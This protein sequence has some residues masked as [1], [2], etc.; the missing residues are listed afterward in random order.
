MAAPAGPEARERAEVAGLAT[1][2]GLAHFTLSGGRGRRLLPLLPDLPNTDCRVGLLDAVATIIKRDGAYACVPTGHEEERAEAAPAGVVALAVLNCRGDVVTVTI[3]GAKDGTEEE[4]EAAPNSVTAAA[5]TLEAAATVPAKSC[6]REG[7][8]ARRG[9]AAPAAPGDPGLSVAAS[10][11]KPSPLPRSGGGSVVERCG[12]LA[13]TGSAG[14]SVDVGRGEPVPTGSAGG[15]VGARRGEP[16]SSGR[17]GRSDVPS[18]APT[19]PTTWYCLGGEGSRTGL[20]SRTSGGAAS[21]GD[22]TMR[23]E[24]VVSCSPICV[25]L[26]SRLRV[27]V[28]RAHRCSAAVLRERSRIH[29]KCTLRLCKLSVPTNCCL[30]SP[31]TAL[32]LNCTLEVRPR[33]IACVSRLHVCALRRQS[34]MAHIL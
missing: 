6:T 19:L 31:S 29:D 9:P 17:I 34:T 33:H 11:G 12:Q 22:L 18:W 21:L 23:C 15:N 13:A 3:G 14:K 24:R 26:L 20:S 4:G 7:E 16:K 28:R 25:L 27:A 8:L 5:K 10:R 2:S 1:S 30:Q 32:N